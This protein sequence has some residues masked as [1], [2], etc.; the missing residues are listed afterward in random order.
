MQRPVGFPAKQGL[1]DPRNEHDACGIGFVVNIKGEKSNKIVRQALTALECLDHRGARGSEENTGDG[2]GILMQIPHAYLS[3]ACYG[4]GIR[5]GDPGSYGVGMI[6]LPQ[7]S[8][9]QKRCEQ[10]IHEIVSSEGLDVIGWRTVPVNPEPLGKTARDCMPVVRQ[11]FID[12]GDYIADDLAFERKLYVI[13]RRVENAVRYASDA[14][15]PE[16]YIPSLSCRTIVYKGMLTP[17]QVEQFYPELSDPAME[18]ALALVHSRFST[19]TFPSWERSHPNRYVIH[20]GEINT[21]RGNENW[22]HAREPKLSSE[23]YGD[24]I[25][26]LKPIIQED[27]SDSAKFDNCF[28]FLSLSGRSM[29]HAMMMMIPEPWEKH[30]SMPPDKRA[31]YEYHSCLMEPW[32]GPAS[33]AFTD[34]VSVGAALDRNGLRPS[35]YYV[36][37]DD[38]VIMASEVGVVE[39]EPED[40]LHKGR[41][42][43]G[44]MFLVDTEQGR[45]IDDEEIKRQ[46]ANEQPYAE[47]LDNNIVDFDELPDADHA[48]P[49]AGVRLH[50][51]R[52]TREHGADGCQL[53]PA[54]WLD[55]ER[56]AAR[57]AVEPAAAPL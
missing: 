5:L 41:L 33:I 17:H 57:R 18:S 30:E 52:P 32:D 8:A 34:G 29:P 20:N 26:S 12:R 53:H 37:K 16:F 19:N 35:R 25:D 36:T 23:L 54:D 7:D 24:A 10:A 31:F 39:V 46:I 6:F 3:H 27:G 14:Q 42:Q 9:G 43:P 11:V 50:V 55:G 21:L 22:M 44:R 45:I 2:A 1:Y 56:R 48:A 15:D 40:V 13:R 47:W 38:T 49:S 4:H 28:E 51:R